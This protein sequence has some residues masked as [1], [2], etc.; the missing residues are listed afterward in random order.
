MVPL[1]DGIVNH[2]RQCEI[3]SGG[4]FFLTAVV[5]VSKESLPGSGKVDGGSLAGNESASVLSSI[6]SRTAVSSAWFTEQSS[7]FTLISEGDCQGAW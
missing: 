1:R 5:R 7:G 4:V 2:P 6:F 3:Y